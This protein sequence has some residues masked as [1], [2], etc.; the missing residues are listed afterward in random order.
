M[1]K[2]LPLF[3][4]SLGTSFPLPEYE[5]KIAKKE[6]I[7][8]FDCLYSRELDDLVEKPQAKT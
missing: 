2:N 7:K 3:N 4:L 5:R 6:E 1:E 8:R